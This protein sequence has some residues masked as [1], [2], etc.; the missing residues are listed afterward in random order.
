MHSNGHPLLERVRN[1]SLPTFFVSD[2][3][4]EN[5]SQ[6]KLNQGLSHL[7]FIVKT[8]A[9]S[10]EQLLQ[11]SATMLE[12]DDLNPVDLEKVGPQSI[13]ALST[14]RTQLKTLDQLGDKSAAIEGFM[15]NNNRIMLLTPKQQPSPNHQVPTLAA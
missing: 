6:T 11:A 9:L 7:T 15:N 13:G 4:P 10:Q 8:D 14:I 2:T 3:P 1:H 5:L 12:L